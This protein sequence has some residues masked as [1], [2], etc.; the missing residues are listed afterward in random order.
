MLAGPRGVREEGDGPWNE[1]QMLPP[2]GPGLRAAP[3]SVRSGS[4]QRGLPERPKS[5]EAGNP[6]CCRSLPVSQSRAAGRSPESLLP[7]ESGPRLAAWERR[8]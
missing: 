8:Q 5:S 2:P 7:P 6:L 3:H 4:D 1:A